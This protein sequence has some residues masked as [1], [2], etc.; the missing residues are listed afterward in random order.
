MI[1]RVD[2]WQLILTFHITLFI[3]F[4]SPLLWGISAITIL[5]IIHRSIVVE[6]ACLRKHGPAWQ[7]YT[8]LV[9]YRFIP[10]VF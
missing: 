10:K 3:G 7:K 4:D 6:D 9:P 1:C 8:A 2:R 5:D